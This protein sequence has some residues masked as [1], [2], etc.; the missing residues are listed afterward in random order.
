MRDPSGQRPAIGVQNPDGDDEDD[1]RVFYNVP[2]YDQDKYR[3]CWAFCQ[4]MIE[5]Y[6]SSMITCR[7]K[8]EQRAI[9]IAKDRAVAEH[10]RT[11]NKGRFPLNCGDIHS[12]DRIYDLYDLLVQNGPLYG[13][14][15]NDSNTSAHL[16]VITGVDTVKNIVYTNN[17][18]GVRGEQQFE[19]FLDGV[20][21]EGN[22]SSQGLHFKWAYVVTND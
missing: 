16:I 11:W 19:D 5:D 1:L 13:Y 22:Q 17:P 2:L 7:E 6:R 21:R 4:V 8:A 3:L 18:W 12:I 20:A 14:Y 15:A 9:K 10:E